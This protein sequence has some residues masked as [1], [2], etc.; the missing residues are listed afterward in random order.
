MR[1]TI[2]C[3][4]RNKADLD[5]FNA[6]NGFALTTHTKEYYV[7]ANVQTYKTTSDGQPKPTEKSE[8]WK[9]HWKGMPLYESEK[10]GEFAKVEFKF[11][12][13]DLELANKIFD[14]PI[15]DRSTSVW[16]PKLEFGVN[17]KV[18]IVKG[19]KDPRYPIF[20]VS[21]GRYEKN[22]TSRYLTQMEVHHYVVVEPQEVEL[23]K[24]YVGNE[25]AE[26][27]ELDMQYKK[28]Y[29]PCDNRNEMGETVGVGPG[30]ARNFCWDYSLKRG[31]KWHW[32]FD[33]NNADGF[34]YMRNNCKLKLRTGAYFAA[35]EDFVD[36]YDNI[37]IAG[38][39]YT[40][41]CKEEDKTPAFVMNTRIYSFL[42][43]RNDIPYR[44]RGRYNEDTDLSLRVLKDG[45]CTVQFN[46][47]LA[48]K[49]T[50]QK[51]KGGN[52]DEF[53][54]NEGTM[55]KS[56]MLEDLHP[57]VAKV[58]WKFHRWHHY[59]D[60]SGFKQK[61]HYRDDFKLEDE[62]VNEYGMVIVDTDLTINT[63][64]K[65]EVEEKYMDNIYEYHKQVIEKPSDYIK[66]KAL[67]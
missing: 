12:E 66:K 52:S 39:N 18:R 34:F 33:D 6:R 62:G 23:Y 31:Y 16:Y 45:W 24:K 63:D 59:V 57:D 44:W 20:V 1:D 58:V 26:I 9:E 37:A 7:H 32:V 53:Y 30:A 8:Y 56:K 43:I 3:R 49:K 61:L 67:F 35:L 47:L 2:I 27:L 51:M 46:S 38:L 55:P 36:R 60:Y 5:E 25:Y 10:R 40:C 14:Q 15:S 4:F 41:F 50:T 29:D 64:T 28:D 65:K 54:F 22:F 19:N 13:D 17:G 42:L 21:K 48:G 11:H